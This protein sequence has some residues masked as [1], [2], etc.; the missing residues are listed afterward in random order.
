MNDVYAGAPVQDG[1]TTMVHRACGRVAFYAL[2]ADWPG[3]IP[4]ATDFRMPDGTTP[5]AHTVMVCGSCGEPVDFSS[6]ALEATVEVDEEFGLT[7]DPCEHPSVNGGVCAACGHDEDRER[8]LRALEAMCDQYLGDDGGVVYCHS[9]M[10]AGEEACEV[11]CELLPDRYEATPSGMRA[12]PAPA[13]VD[14]GAQP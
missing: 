7:M 8:I 9:F 11:L 4:Y 6:T 14:R 12:K 2:L 10:S 5:A 1:T 3:R 13:T